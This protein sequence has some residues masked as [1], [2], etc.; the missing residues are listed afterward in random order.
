MVVAGKAGAAC[1]D[2]LLE[3][4]KKFGFNEFCRKRKNGHS[5]MWQLLLITTKQKS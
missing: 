4:R 1:Q 2:L 3:A 5:V